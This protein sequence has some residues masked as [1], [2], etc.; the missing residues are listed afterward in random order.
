M[1][2]LI[3]RLK[4]SII[5]AILDVKEDRLDE[6]YISSSKGS[7]TRRELANEIIKETEV[8]KRYIET[9]ITLTIDL[10]ERK[11]FEI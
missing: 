2:E 3:K 9:S 8:G 6:H 11:K 5:R 10:L 4:E 1:E 7:F